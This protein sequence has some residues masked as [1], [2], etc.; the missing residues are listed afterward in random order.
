MLFAYYL[1]SMHQR[2]NC[3]H[4]KVQNLGN[5]L[6]M[7]VYN[8]VLATVFNCVG[9]SVYRDYKQV[10]L[11]SNRRVNFANRWKPILKRNANVRP[12]TYWRHLLSVSLG[13]TCNNY[14]SWDVD[15]FWYNLW[16][17]LEY[18]VRNSSCYS[19]GRY[20]AHD[21]TRYCCK[22]EWIFATLLSWM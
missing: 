15:R 4:Y 8:P 21:T 12:L 10:E 9:H 13:N 1:R 11:N 5:Y 3:C 6:S 14:F 17:R 7:P 22:V 18:N 19:M 20:R 16:R 2:A